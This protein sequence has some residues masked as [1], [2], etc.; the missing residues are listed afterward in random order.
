MYSSGEQSRQEI[1]KHKMKW[2]IMALSLMSPTNVTYT[3][4]YVYLKE[5]LHL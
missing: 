4:K 2:I 3:Q 5:A 1:P